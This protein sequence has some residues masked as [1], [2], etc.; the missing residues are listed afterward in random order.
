MK[1]GQSKRSLLRA[2]SASYGKGTDL[3]ALL[4]LK[5]E[6]DE[7]RK[8]ES[9]N[10]GLRKEIDALRRSLRREWKGRVADLEREIRDRNDTLQRRIR[11]LERSLEVA[12]ELGRSLSLLREVTNLARGLL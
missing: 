7:A 5:G 10:A 8:V 3:A 11:R 2:L 4:W 9:A 1:R 6:P 12:T